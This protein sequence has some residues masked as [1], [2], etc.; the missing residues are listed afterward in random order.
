MYLST[1]G[2]IDGGRQFE[3][4]IELKHAGGRS[5]EKEGNYATRMIMITATTTTTTTST[6]IVQITH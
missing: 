3:K 6:S 4:Q 5:V 2:W 1:C